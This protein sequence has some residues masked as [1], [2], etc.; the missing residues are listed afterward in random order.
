MGKWLKRA[1][2]PVAARTA[3]RTASS[4][5]GRSARALPQ[6]SHSEYSVSSSL[7]SA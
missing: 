7:A 3:S 2:R 4:S 5:S 1:S 6:P